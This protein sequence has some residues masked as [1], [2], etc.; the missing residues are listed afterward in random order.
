MMDSQKWKKLKQPG[1]QPLS[2]QADT[3]FPTQV[4][5]EGKDVPYLPIAIHL[6]Q[7]LPAQYKHLTGK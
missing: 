6:K 7:A 4:G 5:K 3:S 2:F 1:Y